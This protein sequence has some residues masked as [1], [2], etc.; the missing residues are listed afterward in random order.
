MASKTTKKTQ[1][2][3]SSASH[4]KSGGSKNQG[5]MAYTGGG[6]GHPSTA[7]HGYPG[8]I[9]QGGMPYTSGHGLPGGP[10]NQQGMPQS[11]PWRKTHKTTAG[12]ISHSGGG[13][14]G[15]GGSSGGGG[16]GGGSGG[17]GGGGGSGRPSASSRVYGLAAANTK[18]DT[19]GGS[20]ITNKAYVAPKYTPLK[21]KTLTAPVSKG[22][23]P[24]GST[25]L[26]NNSDMLIYRPKAVVPA[27]TKM[28][29]PVGG[30]APNSGSRSAHQLGSLPNAAG[31][32]V[33]KQTP[34]PVLGT[35]PTSSVGGYSTGMT[36]SMSA[37]PRRTF[38]PSK[39]VGTP[40]NSLGGG[41][42]KFPAG[43]PPSIGPMKSRV[44]ST[45]L[46]PVRS[47]KAGRGFGLGGG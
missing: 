8:H 16:G 26:T 24:A 25:V 17:G 13:S 33:R 45:G 15:G 19:S 18:V 14:G 40:F 46:G 32:P 7:G 22:V 44:S 41:M 30:F 27:A 4:G 31:T 42:A 43:G 39:G 5:G 11:N 3:K 29:D 38:A 35:G 37:Q 20:A 47:Y 28:A 10:K 9:G 21:Q 36:P 23:A 1:T 6:M 2:K 12:N 34:L